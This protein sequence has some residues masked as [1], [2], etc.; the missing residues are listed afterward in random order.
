[1]RKI[2]LITGGQRS[3]KSSY[4]QKLAEEACEKPVYLAT[5]RYWDED[6]TER[7]RRHQSDRGEQWETVEEDTYL[8][9]LNI[10]GRTVLL[11]CIT[12][13][14]TNL[15]HD[16]NYNPEKA[17]E[18]AKQEWDQFVQNENH[19]LVVSNEIGM[20]I[21]GG[22]EISRKFTDIHGWM[23]QHIAEQADEVI[24]MVSGIPMKI[25]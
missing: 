8:S 3:G 9:K 25:K 23:N 12:L 22:A 16:S 13:W 6:F 1:M 10:T 2:T 17:L 24:L 19:L 21:H 11:D 5:A 7:I 14:L 20:G 15:F 4:A 18:L